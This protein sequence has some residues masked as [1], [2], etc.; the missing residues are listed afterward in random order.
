MNATVQP[1]GI[2][3][4]GVFIPRA[5]LPLNMSA[6]GSNP[7]PA[8]PERAVA[9]FDEDSITLGVAA[10]RDCLDGLDERKAAEVDLVLFA[11]TTAP[12]AEKQG[13]ALIAAA[14]GL[15]AEVRS[16]DITGSTRAGSDALL[17]A[18]ATVQSGSARSALVIAADARMAAP[19]S[20]REAQLGDAAVAIL[21]GAEPL[22]VLEK[23]H[24]ARD[25]MLATWRGAGD[26]FVHGWE[27]RF[28]N[29]HGYIEPLLPL[30][31]QALQDGPVQQ[32]ALPAPDARSQRELAAALDL[33][34]ASLVPALFGQ[35]GHC[36]AAFAPLLLVAALERA[37]DG[38]QMLSADYGDGAVALRWRCI[39]P[40]QRRRLQAALERRR[41]ITD[42]RWYLKSRELWPQEYPAVVDQG[43]SATVHFRER[44]EDLGLIGQVCRCGTHQF[45][46]GRICQRCGSLD[47]FQPAR[48]VERGGRIVTFTHD[49]FFPS[50]EPPT[51]V[52]IVEVDDGPRIHMQVADTTPAEVAV[53]LP[54]RFV[55]R[56]IHRV[57]GKPNYFWKCVP[58]TGGEA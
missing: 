16:I 37:A 15:P 13:A 58:A 5:R 18:C 8:G 17:Q 43:I 49:A 57:G 10:A 2:I 44:G 56:C 36:G 45:P 29:L 7:E 14:L 23:Q 46:R 53:D 12:F 22:A 9:G 39:R 48:Y 42:Y 32:L 54:V 21:I 33:P 41:G 25:S 11:T 30:L 4:W 47:A 51:S 20:A 50:P 26:R 6:A 40:L 19:G 55:F 24:T 1:A 31:R 52:A 38:D 28:V 34:K 35:V 3:R 27:D